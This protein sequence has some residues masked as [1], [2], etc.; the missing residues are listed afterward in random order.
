[1]SENIYASED[2][3]TS[4]ESKTYEAELDGR[5]EQHTEVMNKFAAAILRGEELTASA[6]QPC[7]SARQDRELF[8]LQA[9]SVLL[10]TI[11]NSPF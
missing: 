2:G 7:R 11:Y 8:F 1:M 5:N 9:F 4:I 10:N 3:F 6:L